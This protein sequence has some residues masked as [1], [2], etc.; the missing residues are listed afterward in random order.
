MKKKYSITGMSCAACSAGIERTVKKLGGVSACAVSLMGE[1][2]DVTFDEKILS[3]A[4]IVGAVTGLGYGIFE[5]GKTPEKKREFLTLFVRFLLSLV[6]L[7]PVMY[8]SMGHMVGLPTPM[9]WLNHGFQLG[10]TAVIL[11]INYKF[12]VSGV[13]AAFKLVPNMDTHCSSSRRR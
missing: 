3:E 11:L 4:Q 1:C 12:F 10:I 6:L 8:L 5:Y 13:R 7:L 2:M 9:G